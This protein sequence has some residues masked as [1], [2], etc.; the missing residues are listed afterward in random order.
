[1][2]VVVEVNVPDEVSIEVYDSVTEKINAHVEANGKPEGLIVHVGV[3]AENGTSMRVIDVWDSVEQY[4]SFAE[5]V[6]GPAIAEIAG[7]DAPQPAPPRITE[8]HEL[9]S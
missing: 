3:V 7:P 5:N 1:V 8:V 9:M 6:L 4:Q 2:A